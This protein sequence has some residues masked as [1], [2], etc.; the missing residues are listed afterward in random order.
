MEKKRILQRIDTYIMNAPDGYLKINHRKDGVFYYQCCKEGNSPKKSAYYIKKKDKHLIKQLAQKGY[1]LSV[2]PI[3]EKQV[4]A[5]EIF[6]KN[7]EENKIE[8]IYE[9]LTEER[10]KWIVPIGPSINE[11]IR[12][13]IMEEYEPNKKYEEYLIFDTD[14]GEKVRSKSEVIIANILKK[15]SAY[16]LYKYER[17]LEVMINGKKE[18]IYPDF[19]IISLRT[20]KIKYWEHAGRLGETKYANDFTMKINTYI[21]NNIL[22]GEN[23]LITYET[24]DFPLNIKNVKRMVEELIQTF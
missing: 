21:E 10:K 11:K 12:A 2:K 5:L 19:T 14:N 8:E 15:N 7:Y 9:N 20:G 1:Y 17:P 3:L 13:W 23:L 24:G 6:D 18:I 16:L 22:P 4:Q